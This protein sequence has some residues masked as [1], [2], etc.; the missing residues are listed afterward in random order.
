[1][2][3]CKH[4]GEAKHCD[5]CR[6]NPANQQRPELLAILRPLLIGV[7]CASHQTTDSAGSAA[8]MADV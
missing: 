2:W 3:T 1:M 7:E 4:A 5:S 8:R 6:F